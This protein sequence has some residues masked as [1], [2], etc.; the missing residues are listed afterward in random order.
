MLSA[1]VPGAVVA[2]L[3]MV[4]VGHMAVWRCGSQ[5]PGW[6]SAFCF[7]SARVCAEWGSALRSRRIRMRLQPCAS[8]PFRLP[9][10][11]E[12]AWLASDV[13]VA[14]T[15]M[16]TPLLRT[17]DAGWR[18]YARGDRALTVNHGVTNGQYHQP[19]EYWDMRFY[20]NGWRSVEFG[21]ET[22]TNGWELPETTPPFRRMVSKGIAGI[23]LDTIA[24]AA[25]YPLPRSVYGSCYVVDFGA[26]IQGGLNATVVAGVDGERVT[27]FAG[28]T[29]HPDGTVKW[30]EDNLNDTEYHDVWTLRT[31]RQTIVSHEFKEARYS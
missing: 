21:D 18:V 15:P 24:A 19:H 13:D 23:R 7:C 10:P 25:F 3:A 26:I 22:V 29:L 27:V 4:H 5:N 17:G 1:S 16:S 14:T 11:D 6:W 28:E 30:C 2:V 8:S 20:P 31:G 9:T 12:Q